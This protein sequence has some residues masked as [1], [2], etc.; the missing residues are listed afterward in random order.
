M[1]RDVD[2]TQI[3]GSQPLTYSMEGQTVSASGRWLRILSV[4]DEEFLEGEA[5]RDPEAFV[6]QLKDMRVPGDIFTF[7]Q[8]IPDIV[9]KY[10][11][12]MEWDNFAVIPITTF[13]DW[14]EKRVERDVRKAVNRANRSGVVVRVVELSDAFIEGIQRIYNESPIRQGKPFWH[15]QKDF[16]TIKREN[17]TYQDR[18]ICIGAYYKDDL[19]G[20]IRMLRVGGV[21]MTLQVISM[22]AHSDKKP[23]NAL[24]AK[25]VE[26][27]EMSKLS[28]LVYS[29]YIYNNVHS[30]LTEFKRRNG[31]EQMLVPKYH[32][33][34]T[35]RGEMALRMGLHLP[36]SNWLPQSVLLSLHRIRG[37][38]NKCK[39]RG[40]KSA[41]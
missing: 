29:R 6:R 22:M 38:W 41:S 31:F 30:S 34:L 39:I 1:N 2:E 26:V 19:I 27:C 36:A 37:L 12:Y 25:A 7:S 11:F 13:S 9:P 3:Q 17:S 33:P 10:K 20:F 15:Y 23:T 35:K 40:V 28:H 24:I 5:V 21:A 4:V 18:S 32:V 8:K 16:E 14:L